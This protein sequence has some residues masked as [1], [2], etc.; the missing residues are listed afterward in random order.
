MALLLRF[1]YSLPLAAHK[2]ISHSSES[3]R[4][5][6]SQRLGWGLRAKQPS[7]GGKARPKIHTAGG[8]SNTLIPR[9]KYIRRGPFPLPLYPPHSHYTKP[10]G[11]FKG[12]ALLRLWATDFVGPL[13]GGAI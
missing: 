6:V 13:F 12:T 11:G 2:P 3:T 1:P 4:L 5:P 7:F 10:H 8:L 9:P